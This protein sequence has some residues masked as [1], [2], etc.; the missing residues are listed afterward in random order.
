MKFIQP[1]NN[2]ILNEDKISRMI[3]FIEEQ[4]K[5]TKNKYLEYIPFNLSFIKSIQ[6]KYN[7]LLKEMKE[8][9]DEYKAIQQEN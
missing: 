7:S 9:K 6:N 8:T 1:I 4:E 5:E 2:I 3:E